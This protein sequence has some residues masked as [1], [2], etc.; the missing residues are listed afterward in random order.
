MVLGG[1]LAFNE[2]PGVQ[3]HNQHDYDLIEDLAHLN[4]THIYTD[5]WTC[6]KIAFMS[7]DSLTCV[8]VDG[9][10]LPTYNRYRGYIPAVTSDPHA[11][12]AFPSDSSYAAP[13]G[14]HVSY[15]E[16]KSASMGI[17]Y[18]RFVLDGY[19]VYRPL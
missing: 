6:D 11:A 14:Q 16:N 4:I 13:T 3:A 2:V 9:S 1:L 19:V 8:V 7:N 17:K 12:Y 15:V 18:E 10:L 5:Y